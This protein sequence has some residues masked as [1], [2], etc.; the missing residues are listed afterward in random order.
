MRSYWEVQDSGFGSTVSQVMTEEEKTALEKVKNSLTV[1]ERRYQENGV[2]WKRGRPNL[3]NNRSLAQSRLV[4]TEKALRKNPT[5][6]EEYSRT[7]REYVEKEYLQ[8]IHPDQEMAAAQW[9]LP[10]FPV[11]RM[12]KTTTKVRL[13]SKM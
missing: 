9:Y 6:A 12:N 8:K 10:H 3:P 4:S 5:V 2:P 7:I 11:V 13:L 1:V